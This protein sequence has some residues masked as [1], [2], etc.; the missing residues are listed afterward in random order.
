MAISRAHLSILARFD[1]EGGSG[2]L[3][4]HGRVLVGPTKKS[5]MPGDTISWLRLVADGLV[6]GER[7]EMIITEAGRL[8]VHDYQRGLVRSASGG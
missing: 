8:V 2:V 1:S 5:I 3:D 6:A 7:G 4:P